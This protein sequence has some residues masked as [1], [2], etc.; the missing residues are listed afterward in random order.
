MVQPKVCKHSKL[1]IYIYEGSKISFQLL[2]ENGITNQRKWENLFWHL[3][4]A[5]NWNFRHFE[6]EFCVWLLLFWVDETFFFSFQRTDKIEHSTVIRYLFLKSNIPTKIKEMY[7]V[8]RNSAPSF[9]M[10]KFWAAKFKHGHTS[11]REDECSV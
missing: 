6:C 4:I 8:Y 1:N 7:A 11:L 2:H 3:L 5:L 9:M 10:V